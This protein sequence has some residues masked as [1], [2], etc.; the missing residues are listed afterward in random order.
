VRCLG[1]I[2]ECCGDVGVSPLY[3]NCL[4]ANQRLFPWKYRRAVAGGDRVS[5]RREEEEGR[6]VAGAWRCMGIYGNQAR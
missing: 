5:V 4:E 3:G 2:R 1:Q 6:R